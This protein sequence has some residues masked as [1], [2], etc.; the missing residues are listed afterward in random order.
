M[1]RVH[2]EGLN[3]GSFTAFYFQKVNYNK[4]NKNVLA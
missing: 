3:F 2:C 4:V 1:K